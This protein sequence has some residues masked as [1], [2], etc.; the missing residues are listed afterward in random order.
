MNIK[1]LMKKKLRKL[2][3]SLFCR[4]LPSKVAI[5]EL[6]VWNV[7]ETLL[8]QTPFVVSGGV[9]ND[10][11]FELE[12]AKRYDCRVLLYD[13]SAT[14][15]GTACEEKNISPNIQFYPKGLAGKSG[16]HLFSLPQDA[17]EGSFSVPREGDLSERVTFECVSLSDVLKSA[18]WQHAGLLKIDV[19]GFEYEILD[20][21][22]DEA[23][24]AFSQICVEFHHFLP[25]IKLTQTL[26]IICKLYSRGYRV[27]HKSQCDYLFIHKKY[28]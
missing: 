27:I 22:L 11:S 5:G 6:C 13:P 9:G 28:L 19:E 20:S 17:I 1:I 2:F 18:G 16:G 10:M 4:N 25:D 21:L 14:G 23:P 15:I 3:D 26:R 8:K 12:I 24:E 7:S